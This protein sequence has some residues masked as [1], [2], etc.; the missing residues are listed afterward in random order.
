M[1]FTF[2]LILL[3]ATGPRLLNLSFDGICVGGPAICGIAW[4]AIIV[5]TSRCNWEK[6]SAGYITPAQR[7]APLLILLL[8]ILGYLSH[9]SRIYYHNFLWYICVHQK[10]KKLK[11][12]ITCCCCCCFGTSQKKG[13]VHYRWRTSFNKKLTMQCY[14]VKLWKYNAILQDYN[15]ILLPLLFR[16]AP[17]AGKKPTL[18]TTRMHRIAQSRMCQ[19]WPKSHHGRRLRWGNPGHNWSVEPGQEGEIRRAADHAKELSPPCNNLQRGKGECDCS[20]W[21]F[22]RICL[23]QTIIST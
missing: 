2:V 13:A 19:D 17:R 20:W 3:I 12:R 7:I 23:S 6:F 11:P 5:V 18:K 10:F 8:V 21:R 9:I 4:H 16:Q 14:N 15:A 1:S 22:P